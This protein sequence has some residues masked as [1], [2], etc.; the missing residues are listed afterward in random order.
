[1]SGCFHDNSALGIDAGGNVTVADDVVYNT[2]GIS[3]IGIGLGEGATAI[4]DVVYNGV[5]GVEGGSVSFSRIYD[6]SVAGIV[7][8]NQLI[9]GNVLF[10]NGVGIEAQGGHTDH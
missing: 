4:D 5:T 8:I 6:Q 7:E 9:Q 1:M 3:S 2:T 10:G